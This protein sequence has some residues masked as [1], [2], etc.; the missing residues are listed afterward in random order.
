MASAIFLHNLRAMAAIGG[1]MLIAQSPHWAG[2][3]RG[4]IQRALQHGGE[5]L[6]GAGV[7]TNLI[8]IGAAFGAYGIRMVRAALPK[9]WVCILILCATE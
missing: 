1:L 4:S 5:V 3:D 6:V 2:R 9:S 8:V 7:A